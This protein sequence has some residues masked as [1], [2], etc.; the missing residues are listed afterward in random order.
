MQTHSFPEEDDKRIL[1][2][3]L[4]QTKEIFTPLNLNKLSYFR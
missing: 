4:Y 2:F 1:T 3:E